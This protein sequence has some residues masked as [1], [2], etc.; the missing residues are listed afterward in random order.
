MARYECDSYYQM[1]NDHH[2]IPGN[3]WFLCTM[4]L[5]QWHIR[6]AHTLA[7]LHKPVELL[8]WC[9]SHALESGVMAEQINPHSGAPISVSPLTWSHATYVETV[10][11]L[12]DRQRALQLLGSGELHAWDEGS[13][14]LQLAG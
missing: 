1:S 5:A 10:C 11:L 13:N 6:K 9:I 14:R 4:W 2:N 12:R 7:D 8:R 3:P